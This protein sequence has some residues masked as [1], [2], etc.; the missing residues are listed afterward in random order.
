M[1]RIKA[2]FYT[3]DGYKM[4]RISRAMRESLP[5][6]SPLKNKQYYYK[7][8]ELP[9]GR[10]YSGWGFK[11]PTNITA[12][13]LPEDYILMHNYKK[14]GYIRASGIKGLVYSR[15]PFHNH[16]FKDDFLY[17][18]YKKEL[19]HCVK[20][21]GEGSAF[22]ECDEYIFGNDIVDFI[23]A[24]KKYSPLYNLSDIEDAM[25]EQYN[26]YCDE[27]NEHGF[28]FIKHEKIERFEEL[29]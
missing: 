2:N 26:M 15:S 8:M 4:E 14:H 7:F 23:A 9:D 16:T 10:L 19:K 3:I 17:I 22:A 20:G 25:V 11:Y 21:Y 12:E 24:A 18:S 29:C 13:D 27:M 6:D 5:D 1:K 28:D